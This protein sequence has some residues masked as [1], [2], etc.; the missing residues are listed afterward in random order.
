VSRWPAAPDPLPPLGS[1][2]HI[3]SVALDDPAL[4]VES[5]RA[6][7][8]PDEQQRADKFKFERDRRRHAIAHAALRDILARYTQTDAASLQF[9]T[10]ADGKPKLAPPLVDGVDFNLSHSHERALVAVNDRREIG[11]DIEFVKTDF[12]FLEVAEHFFSVREVA[13]LNDLPEELQRRAFYKCWTSKEAFLKAKG[14][15]LSGALD[16]VE[17][18]LDGDQVRI[19]ASVAGWALAELDFGNAYEAALVTQNAPMEVSCYSWRPGWY[20]GWKATS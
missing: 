7:L 9:I 6:R 16:E 15:G 10:G 8:S 12:E 18:T 3:W 20:P 17:I 13:A 1:G 2:A 11:V 14:T 5:C 19:V 4:R